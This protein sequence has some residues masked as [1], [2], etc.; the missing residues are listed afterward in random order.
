MTLNYPPEPIAAGTVARISDAEHGIELELRGVS[1]T[2][3]SFRDREYEI[4]I[5]LDGDHYRVSTVYPGGFTTRA[6]APTW[7]DA[8]ERGVG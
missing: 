7:A 4:E 1:D 3:W 8:I 6:L 5:E 2:L